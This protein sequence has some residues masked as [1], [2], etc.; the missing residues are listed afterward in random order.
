MVS[1]TQLTNDDITAAAGRVA[2]LMGGPSAEREISLKSGRAVTGALVRSGIDAR[3]LVWDD[4]LVTQLLDS[5][6]LDLPVEWPPWP[7]ARWQL[8]PW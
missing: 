1:A 8:S 2:V 4:D 5:C 7:R 6:F 3:E